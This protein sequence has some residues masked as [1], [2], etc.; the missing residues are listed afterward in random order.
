M[1]SASFTMTSARLVF[2]A[3]LAMAACGSPAKKDPNAP[4]LDPAVVSMPSEA[5]KSAAI[6]AAES[7][8]VPKSL[9]IPADSI[10]RVFAVSQGYGLVTAMMINQDVRML[11]GLYAG[12]ATLSLP[13]STVHGVVAIVRQ[14][15]TLART[16][17]LAEFQRTSKGMRILDDSTLADSGT[18]VMTSK[19][20]PKETV[21][22]R[23]RYATTWRARG[24]DPGSWVMTADRITPDGTKGRK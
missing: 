14:L 10:Q 3:A 19:R 21:S 11:G 17:A 4:A 7:A 6:K 13:D 24:N 9:L 5:Q 22:E 2:V 8:A 12:D 1:N 23:G 16:K 18:Y 20:T 15:T